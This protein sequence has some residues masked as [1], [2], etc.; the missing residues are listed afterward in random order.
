LIKSLNTREEKIM[1]Y[2]WSGRFRKE[3]HEMAK[4]FTFSLDIDK[5]LAIFDVS[6]SIAHAE[7]LIRQKIISVRDGRK[8]TSGL[9][10]IES[11]IRNNRFVF[12]KDEDIHTAIER[13]LIEIIGTV[14]GKLH[15]ARSRNDQ[16][17]L[18]EKL[19]LKNILPEIETSIKILQKTLVAKAEEW[20]GIYLPEFT[21]LQ[22]AQPVL[23]SHHLLAYV[24]MLERD[25]KRMIDALKRINISPL[26]ACACT[27]TSFDIDPEYVAKKFG[28]EEVFSNSIDAVSDRDF[29]LEIISSSG[30]L[31]IHLSRMSE[32]LI[33]WHSP[34]ISFV[35]LPEEFCTGS[36]IMPQKKNPDVLELIRGR[37]ST[38][39]G[40]MVGIF[41]LMKGLPL[42]YNRDLQED[43]RFLFETCEISHVSILIMTEIIKRTEIHAEKM[44]QACNYGYIEATDIAEFLTRKG[45][46]FRQAHHMVA[47]LVEISIKKGIPLKDLDEKTINEIT[48][49]S[50]TVRFIKNLNPEKSI[51]LKN[52]PGGTGI[53]QVKKELRKW[54]NILI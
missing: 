36:S 13:R 2:L 37:T 4:N 28:F 26:G 21:H 14:G 39:L 9:R 10:K 40:N 32:E 34:L 49:T 53:N 43:K 1:K 29:I 44:K 15:T 5:N 6:G 25:R 7:M 12:D 54:K 46:P 50:D 33:F 8:I 52:S 31:M 41:S 20:L 3:L 48:G 24:C 30:I 22:P 42:S 18:D 17:V 16:I 27:G 51:N 19:F 38:V 11:E 47:R 45:V 23:L 35:D